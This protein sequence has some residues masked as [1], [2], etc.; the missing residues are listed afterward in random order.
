MLLGAQADEILTGLGRQKEVR[1]FQSCPTCNLA[2]D[3][4]IDQAALQVE[5]VLQ[6]VLILQLERVLHQDQMD[7]IS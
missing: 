2:F 7:V 6:P 1:V 4:A 3:L 5:D